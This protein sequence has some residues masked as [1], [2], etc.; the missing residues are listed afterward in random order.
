MKDKSL[1]KLAA[2]LA[3]AALL[4]GSAQ[5]VPFSYQATDLLLGFRNGGASDFVVDLG[6]VSSWY[7]YGSLQPNTT[8]NITAF[9]GAQLTSVFGNLNNISFSAFADVRTRT[10][11]TFPIQTLWATAPRM[12]IN[13]QSD[14]LIRRSQFQQANTG[15]KIDGIATGAINFSGLPDNDPATNVTTVT[16][17]E[18]PSTWNAGGGTSYSLGVGTAGNF[19]GTFPAGVENT[20]PD[21]FATG[22]TPIVSDLY[23]LAP[24]SSPGAEGEYLGSFIFNP[25]GSMTFHTVPEPGSMSLI[26]AGFLLLGLGKSFRRKS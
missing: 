24:N 9:S 6:P 19:S 13:V 11:S 16:A 3:G 25:D 8:Y 18:I 17:L 22:G 14:P 7:T 26:G 21:G 20:T 12:D 5:A 10:N 4:G 2:G 23:A 1:A 15:A